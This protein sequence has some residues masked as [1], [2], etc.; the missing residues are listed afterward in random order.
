M[1]SVEQEVIYVL[2]FSLVAAHSKK[3]LMSITLST[4]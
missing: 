3:F 4:P 2:A 1:P